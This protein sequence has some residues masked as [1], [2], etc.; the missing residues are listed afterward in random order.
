[1]GMKRPHTSRAV[2]CLALVVSLGACT[3]LGVTN[4]NDPDRENLVEPGD[5][6]SLVSSSF[7]TW[8]NGVYY[9]CGPGLGLSNQTFQHNAPWSNCG[10][11]QYGRIP[12]AGLNNQLA[13]E[14][15]VQLSRVWKESY[16]ANAAVADGLGAL[17]DPEIS[18]ELGPEMVTQLKA[19]GKFIQGLSLATLALFYDRG[20]VVDENTDR[21]EPQGPVD[22]SALMEAALA[23]FDDAID[24]ANSA[25]FDLPVHWMQAHLTS[26]ELA[27]LAH[28]YQ[29]RFRAQVART[30]EERAAVDWDSVI[31]DVDSGLIST[32][33]LHMDWNTNWENSFLHYA[34]YPNW[35][36]L[37][38]FM[39]GMADQG[40]DVS[41]WLSLPLTEKSYQFADGRPVLIVTPDL[42]FPQGT[43]V[44]EQRGNPGTYFRITPASQVGDT[45]QKPGRG[46]WR[47]SWYKP[48]YGRGL[49]YGS[50]GVLDQPEI[51][52]AEM[53]LLK[54]EGLYRT[55][56]RAGAANIIN[57]TRVPSGLNAT[58]A[59]GTNTSCVP[60][61]PDGSCGDLWEMLK[62]EKRMET[63]WTGVAGAAWFF[64]GRGWGDLWKGTPL[65]FPISC[66]ELHV[67][68][69]LPCNTFGGPGGELSSPG[70]TYNFP[71]EG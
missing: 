29:A 7:N 5:V 69:L 65:Q 22:Y 39:Y 43:T 10:M 44:E 11:D 38:Y 20:F 27:L 14:H 45:W 42:R 19:F 1:M 4:N 58:D 55:G 15:Y 52:L 25:T 50:L 57:E 36:Q 40:G 28:S 51:T 63:V 71:F 12:R 68:E 35:S 70:S 49:D 26:Q 6:V 3:D 53:R 37:A 18:A 48:G 34:T 31:D 16:R 54:A 46:T 59:S 60:K 2:W 32:L 24:L 9:Y 8:F 67:L 41:E 33:T 64:D 61:L 62:W 56:D 30:P 23:Y 21:E 13:N 17:D 66:P 47:W